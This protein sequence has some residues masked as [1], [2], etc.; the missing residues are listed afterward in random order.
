[1]NFENIIIT[2]LGVLLLLFITLFILTAINKAN[3]TYNRSNDGVVLLSICALFWPA[4]IVIGIVE[5][6][7]FLVFWPFKTANNVLASYIKKKRKQ[8]EEQGE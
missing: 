6:C 8:I 4:V 1:M 3:D 2:Y 7:G 5:V